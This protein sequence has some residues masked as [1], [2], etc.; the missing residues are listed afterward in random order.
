MPLIN[1]TPRTTS[2][3]PLIDTTPHTTSDVS[4]IDTT[5]HKTSDMSLIGTTSCNT[6]NTTTTSND[7]NTSK[8]N[9]T[10]DT[11]RVLTSTNTTIVED[12]DNFSDTSDTSQD[13]SQSLHCAL[14][15]SN[16]HS[17]STVAQILQTTKIPNIYR[18]SAHLVGH[19]PHNVNDFSV[20]HCKTC[21]Q[22]CRNHKFC[23]KC[24]R[25]LEDDDIFYIFMFELHL[26]DRSTEEILKVLVFGE[27]AISLLN[28]LLPDNLSK[29]I[30][31][32]I[33]LFNLFSH[34]LKTKIPVELA[35]VSYHKRNNPQVTLYQVKGTTWTLK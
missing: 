28:G 32:S 34:L 10:F 22:S 29:N 5:P 4:L 31:T 25:N 26:K 9:T 33:L 23:T 30:S 2:D 13:L 14:K 11:K 17:L 12:I 27:E 24:N 7:T 8:T 1:T 20:P 16:L 18:L 19:F 35:I 21:K 15:Y 6:T 3:V